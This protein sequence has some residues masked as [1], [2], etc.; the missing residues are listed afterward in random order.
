MFYEA[1]ADLIGPS[2]SP[3][4]T[5]RRNREA[6]QAR[7]KAAKEA[8]EAEE[9]KETDEK[10]QEQKRLSLLRKDKDKDGAQGKR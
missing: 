3:F 8:K 7:D 1:L 6:W 2:L 9:V 5:L 10:P 4:E